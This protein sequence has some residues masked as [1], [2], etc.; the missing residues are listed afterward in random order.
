MKQA[1][2]Q[3]VESDRPVI[4][5][6][7]FRDSGQ[8][9]PR[10]WTSSIDKLHLPQPPVK[11]GSPSCGTCCKHSPRAPLIGHDEVT[12]LL[13]PFDGRSRCLVPADGRLLRSNHQ[14]ADN[15]RTAAQDG[16]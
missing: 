9:V 15:S 3:G 10:Q 4:F 1:A 11:C 16:G 2:C 12:P 7:P 6:A 13:S 5:G 8:A 14:E